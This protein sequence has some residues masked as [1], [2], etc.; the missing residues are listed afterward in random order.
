MFYS[1]GINFNLSFFLMLERGLGGSGLI[2]LSL[3]S[4]LSSPNAYNGLK[5]LPLKELFLLSVALCL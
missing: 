3:N 5:S 2:S 1:F 4:A